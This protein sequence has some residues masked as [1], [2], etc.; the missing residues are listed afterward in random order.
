MKKIILILL[1]LGLVCVTCIPP[2]YIGVEK[3]LHVRVGLLENQDSVYFSS[4]GKLRIHTLNGQQTGELEAGEWKVQMMQSQ[5]ARK[6]FRLLVSKTPDEAVASKRTEELVFKGLKAYYKSFGRRI[7]FNNRL[8]VDNQIFIIYLD[9]IFANRNEAQKYQN[10][11]KNIAN[12]EI[13][14]DFQSGTDGT[15]WLTNLNT[16]AQFNFQNGLRLVGNPITL[17]KQNAGQGFHFQ[18]TNVRQYDGIIELK[19]N[20]QGKLTVINELPI[21]KYLRG[22]VPAEMPP[23]YPLEALKAQAIAAR[24][25]LLKKMGIAHQFQDFDVCDEVHCQAYN[26][27]SAETESTNRAVAETRGLILKY[28]DE[29]CNTVFSAV[30]GGHTENSTKVWNGEEV[31]YLTGVVDQELKNFTS[32]QSYFESESFVHKWIESA[33]K[34]FCNQVDAAIP[35]LANGSAKYF[36]WQVLYQPHELASIIKEKTKQDVGQ[37]KSIEPIK[38]GVSGRLAEIQIVGTR[39]K[40]RIEGELKIRQALAPTALYSACFIVDK[41]SD[42]KFL[43]KGAG[44]GHGVGMCQYG[45]A[46]MALQGKKAEEILLHYYPGTRLDQFY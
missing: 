26:G 27:L 23:A 28:Y 4:G 24:T 46:G 32:L 25:V 36:R 14:E 7:L 41:T 12:T 1:A 35:V 15:I 33:P 17:E 40:I 5:P 45:A 2:R 38:R 31:P 37:I 34:S 13:I 10:R 39:Q 6:V 11:I 16:L 18:S 21:E 22:V 8:I 43:I 30:C 9:E 20:N 3:G 19:I 29:L 42:G 44:F